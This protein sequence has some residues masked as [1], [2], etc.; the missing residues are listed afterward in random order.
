MKR[1][2]YF[3][4]VMAGLLASSILAG[5]QDPG[6]G[7]EHELLAHFVPTKLDKAKV[8]KAGTVLSVQKDGIGAISPNGGMSMSRL[9]GSDG[10]IYPNNYKAGSVKHDIR[11]NFLASAGAIR[12]LDVNEKVYLTKVEVKDAS[13]IVQVQSCGTCDPKLP[14]PEHV[15]ARA[16]VNFQLGKQYLAAATPAQV[17][18]VIGHV[19]APVTDD[20]GQ[21][22]SPGDA[23]APA[24]PAAPPDAPAAPMAPIPPP[25]PP[26]D[27][28]PAP[29][30]E[31]KIG[32][33]T[34]EVVAAMGQPVQIFN[35]GAKMIYKYKSLK[36]TFVNGKVS[37][38]E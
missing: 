7:L 35:L 27:A 16:S 5:A 23:P 28:P 29:P 12:D 14:D 18:E 13:V 21:G 30:A 31:I 15:P 33:S 25:P 3:A 4:G 2:N 24:A 1:L 36:I 32:Q 37:D 8:V 22:V 19:F 20:G 38:V 11:G 6:S 9:A 26:A 10:A 17:I 34:A